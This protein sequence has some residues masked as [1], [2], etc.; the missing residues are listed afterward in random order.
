[1]IVSGVMKDVALQDIDINRLE[2][3]GLYELRNLGRAIGVPRPTTLGRNELIGAI[4]NQIKNGSI[5]GP[6]KV[7]RGRKPR[8]RGFDMTKLVA[9]EPSFLLSVYDDDLDMYL[10]RSGEL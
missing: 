4:K 8:E 5:S 3:L 6:R 1:M 9:S 10:V 2:M 7:S